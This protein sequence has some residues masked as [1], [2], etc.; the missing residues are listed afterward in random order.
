MF[1]LKSSYAVKGH[2]WRMRKQVLVPQRTCHCMSFSTSGH[3]I[4]KQKT[5]IATIEVI[6]QWTNHNI[7][8]FLLNA[9][10][11]LKWTWSLRIVCISVD[12][13]L[14]RNL[15]L[16][17]CVIDDVYTAF[18]IR[19]TWWAYPTVHP[20]WIIKVCLR[21]FFIIG[22]LGILVFWE[23][24]WSHCFQW[25]LTQVKTSWQLSQISNFDMETIKTKTMRTI[26]IVFIHCWK[27]I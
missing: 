17:S 22:S 1:C 7:K 11:P 3:T 12:S 25:I 2:V 18:L 20:N 16:H 21:S 13:V 4:C 19:K 10:Y 5:I 23:M 26:L 8:K 9:K 24:W 15:D 6:Y 27:D 14:L